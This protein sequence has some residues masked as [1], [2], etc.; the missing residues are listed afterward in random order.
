[1]MMEDDE[2]DRGRLVITVFVSEVEGRVCG[3]GDACATALPQASHTS[4]TAERGRV[5]K[6]F[7]FASIFFLTPHTFFPC[8][9]KKGWLAM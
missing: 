7:L 6:P 5:Y 2:G 3:L 1:M 9:L 4:S 8:L